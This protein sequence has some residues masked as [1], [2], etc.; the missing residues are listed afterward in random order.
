MDDK[1]EVAKTKAQRRKEVCDIMR[2][3]EEEIYTLSPPRDD[4]AF[5]LRRKLKTAVEILERYYMKI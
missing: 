2:D 4:E 5:E 3:L 1:E